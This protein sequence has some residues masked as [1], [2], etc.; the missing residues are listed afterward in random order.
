MRMLIHIVHRR[1]QLSA[2][3]IATDLQTSRGLQISSRAARREL[4][5]W[6]STAEQLR[7]RFTLQS[8]VG[9]SGVKH[10]TTGL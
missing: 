8:S 6:V 2:E 3:L 1:H 5:E 10:T 9:Y 7:Q 4:H